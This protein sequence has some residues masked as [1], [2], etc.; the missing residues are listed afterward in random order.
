MNID[1]AVFFF[2]QDIVMNLHFLSSTAPV[3]RADHHRIRRVQAARCFAWLAQGFAVAR[4]RPVA[5]LFALLACADLVTLF[6]LAPRL[7]VL[8]PLVAPLAMAMFVLMQ[9]RADHARPWTFG[10]TWG[11]VDEHR[12]ALLAVGVAAAAMASAGYF[13]ATMLAHMHGLRAWAWLAALPF[14]GVAFASFWF[15]PA[16]IVL[17]NRTPLDAMMTSARAVARNWP[18]ALIYAAVMG[19][20]AF[21]VSAMPMTLSGVVVTP[22]LAV[23]ILLGAYASYRDLLGE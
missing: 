9:E 23:L 8:A 15:A 10:E 3:A 12:D 13:A 22:V 5:W 4:L 2:E 20:Y 6:E 7:S 17:R 21:A 14:Y 19:A 11:A 18:V 16:L 1:N